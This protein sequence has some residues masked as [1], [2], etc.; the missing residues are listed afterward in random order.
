MSKLP[1][2]DKSRDMV[3]YIGL[4]ALQYRKTHF[5]ICK[6]PDKGT[7]ICSWVSDT[8][9]LLQDRTSRVGMRF[10]W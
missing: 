9:Y 6:E 2:M 3:F 1:I 8:I 7:R 4:F 10:G 5:I